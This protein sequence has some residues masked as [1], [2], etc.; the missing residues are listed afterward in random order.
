MKTAPEEMLHSIVARFDTDEKLVVSTAYGDGGTNLLFP[1]LVRA[2][3]NQCYD[4][5][6]MV[7]RYAIWA[8]TARDHISTAIH[9]IENN[10]TEQAVRLLI[11]AHNS[12]SAFS[13]IQKHL[14]PL[15]CE[16][17]A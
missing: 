16:T 3:M 6:A 17:E 9:L 12:L 15:N 4:G 13:E 1:R 7:S 14:D 10:E 8:N 11:S 5:D 2:A